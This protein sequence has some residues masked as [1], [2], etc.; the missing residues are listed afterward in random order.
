MKETG[1]IDFFADNPFYILIPFFCPLLVRSFIGMLF[2]TPQHKP[3][4]AFPPQLQ[5]MMFF[6]FWLEK[7]MYTPEK[8]RKLSNYL[9]LFSICFCGTSMIV[10]IIT[11]PL[12]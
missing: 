5:T 1:I 10:M 8:L 9:L 7:G 6:F 2:L 4:E 12:S 11:W 3:K